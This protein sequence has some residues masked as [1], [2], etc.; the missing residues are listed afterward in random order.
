M[1]MTGRI[2]HPLSLAAISFLTWAA[3]FSLSYGS[4]A[5]ACEGRLPAGGFTVP[6]LV[7]VGA[8]PA[9]LVLLWIGHHA[10]RS[11]ARVEG[12]TPHFLAEFALGSALLAALAILWQSLAVLV[13]ASC[14]GE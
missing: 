4:N 8:L 9:L 13:I 7:L 14:G 10:W 3:H 12:H 11:R 2:L 6:R 5:L 1:S